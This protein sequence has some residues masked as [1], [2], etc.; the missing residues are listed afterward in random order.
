M[1]TLEGLFAPL[2]TPFTDDGSTVSEIRF[3]RQ[4]RYLLEQPVDGF[5]IGTE[6]GEFTSVSSS[7]RKQ[8]LEWGL[9]MTTGR[10]IMVNVSSMNTTMSLDLAQHA[11]RHGAR[12]VILMPPYYGTFTAEEIIGFIRNVSHYSNMT[13]VV[14]DP[15]QVITSEVRAGLQDSHDLLFA[16]DIDSSGH[17]HLSCH[18]GFTST[19]EFAVQECICSP[20]ALLRPK[21]VAS[22]MKGANVDL[23]KL[24]IL[25]ETLGRTR[26]SKA[27]LEAVGLDMG[28]PRPPLRGLGGS[29]GSVLRTLL[30]DE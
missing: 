17:S 6:C 26:V 14:V 21:L 8:L 20:L 9:R 16:N 18:K 1:Q 30:A 23:A 29:V 15:L 13:T 12:A 3:A 25:E 27:G 11:S 10:P 19:D 22:A 5:A 7:E 24:I 4:I 28:P 2:V